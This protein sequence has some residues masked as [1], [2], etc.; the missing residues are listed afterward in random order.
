MSADLRALEREYASVL[1]DYVR[2]PSEAAL[3]RAY[4]IGRRALA[5]GHGV[6]DMASL[7]AGALGELAVA[8]VDRAVAERAAEVFFRE[9][10][11]SF[12]MTFRGYREANDELRKVNDELLRQKEAAEAANRELE[13]F[14]YSVSHDLRA[15]LRSIDGFSQALLDDC[16]SALDE[17]GRRYLRYVRESAQEM[18]RLI[19]G[20]LDLS[21][22]TRAG[23][24]RARVDLAALA[25]SILERLAAADPGRR[26]EIVVPGEIPASADPALLGIAL[27]NLLGN[28]WKF[29]SKRPL[30][31]IE[32]GVVEQPGRPVYFVRDD[33]A[34][35]DMAHARRLFG[36]FQRLHGE[37]E[38]AG[39]GIGLA[40]VARIVHRHRGEV[41]AE[42]RVGGGATFY[43][44]LGPEG[45]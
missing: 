15:P 9:L 11:S 32:V 10:L 5:L 35:F 19:D 14:S 16:G 36:A 2:A 44:T 22:V 17:D 24:H 3:S 12:E 26:V 23:L 33:G 21:R 13:A 43:F 20:L 27:Q 37:R 45:P 4:G 25:R 7:H 29:T 18:E 31:R 38:F 8:G 6:L 41:W 1:E 40:T 39:T 30:G 42:G 28:A 34:G